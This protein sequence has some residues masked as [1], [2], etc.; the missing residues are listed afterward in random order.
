MND[1]NT[2]RPSPT[3]F[4]KFLPWACAQYNTEVD[5]IINRIVQKPYV[6]IAGN[7]L[8]KELNKKASQKVKSAKM[9]LRVPSFS[10]SEDVYSS[11]SNVKSGV[12][13]ANK[14]SYAITIE[15][16]YDIDEEL[17]ALKFLKTSIIIPMKV[18]QLIAMILPYQKQL[19]SI[20]INGGLRMD[21]LYVI[22]KFLP[23]SQI[24]ELCFDGTFLDKANY[25]ILLTQ[26]KLKHLSLA[27]CS[28]NDD[29]VKLIT[30]QLKEQR[31]AAKG[32]CALN[33]STNKIT[34]T[35]AKYIADM[36]RSNR[37]LCYL[38]LAGNTITDEGGV[39][40]LDTLQKFIVHPQELKESR[41]RY[42]AYLKERHT[43]IDKFIK[44]LQDAVADK[45]ATKKKT[46]KK[47]KLANN[48]SIIDN[49]IVLDNQML[50]DKAEFLANK[51]L[52]VYNESFAPQNTEA[53]D[54][55]VYCLGNNSLCCLNLAYNNLS[56]I[57]LKKLLDVLIMQKYLNRN[58][59]GLIK[60]VIEGNLMPIA[61]E[62]F[63]KIDHLLESV[64][65]GIRLKSESLL[66]KKQMVSKPQRPGK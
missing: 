19:A 18:M 64:T 57:S 27:R 22:S 31:P 65:R 16:I 50:E 1:P 47:Y 43:L 46:T 45:N 6:N 42:V 37:K 51:T 20:T 63:E 49:D 55:V 38:N 59:R 3:D 40:I 26:N 33:L 56:Y 2:N 36:L 17:V 9:P 15:T 48:L 11:I 24:T 35:G 14:V 54:G 41:V 4:D 10:D 5:I 28:I 12:N 25:H 8:Y 23:N 30:D 32:L 61:C 58:P 44:E 29:I 39:R 60:V 66:K 53:R 21:T 62:E 13:E 52:G 34:D 7:V